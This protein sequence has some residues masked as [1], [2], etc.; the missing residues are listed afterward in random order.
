MAREK[1]RFPLFDRERYL[2]APSC[3]LPDDLQAGI[4]RDGIRNSHLTAIAPTGT[5][6]LLAGNVS[7]GLEPVYALSYQRRVRQAN[8]SATSVPVECYALAEYARLNGGADP[9]RRSL[10]PSARSL[11]PPSWRCR[12]RCRCTSI[13]RSPRR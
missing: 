4:G 2:S 6:S 11:P 13:T 12:P 9:F 3:T 10:S 7:S 1:G 5:I 8:G